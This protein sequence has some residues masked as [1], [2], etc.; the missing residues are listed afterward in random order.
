MKIGLLPLYI[1]LYDRTSPSMR[2]RLEAFYQEIAQEFA[3]RGVEVETSPFCRLKPEFEQAVGK[4]EAAGVDALV[5]LH[6]AYSPSLESID[7]LA[8]TALPI[9]VLDTTETLE[10]TNGQDPVEID[11][12]HGI[13]GVMDMC[14]MLT[15]E[16]KDYAVA[17]G[18]YRDSDVLD[19]VCGYVRAA[20][21]AGALRGA[22]VGLV[23]GA[24]DGMGDFR[25]P[26]EELKERFGVE[27]V[28]QK[29]ERM[30]GWNAAVS[31]A[32]IDAEMSANAEAFDFAG[33]VDPDEYRAAVRSCLTLRR[34]LEE[35]RLSS[36]SVNFTCI[37][38]D[39]GLESMP[40][41]EC[42]KAMGRGIGY[43]GRG[44]RSPPR[45]SGR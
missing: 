43:V 19:R 27:V 38:G 18:H 22:R 3:K 1:A 5:T 40:F 25:V 41:L 33:G 26:Y 8:G 23:G 6:M 32:E 34:C 13:H 9:V 21:A 12:N 31:E 7:V 2:P 30:R 36:F 37:G 35:D 17:A 24:F 44:M 10:F 28:E 42:C 29:A 16:G 39:S 4:F 15:R 11:Y 20:K 14:S 45:S